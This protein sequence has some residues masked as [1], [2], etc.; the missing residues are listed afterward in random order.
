M[1][2][3]EMFE[4]VCLDDLKPQRLRSIICKAHIHTHRAGNHP[5][6]PATNF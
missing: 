2:Q 3:S 5:S 4:A 6:P 1:I